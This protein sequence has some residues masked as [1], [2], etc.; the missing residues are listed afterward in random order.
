[1]RELL[2]AEIGTPPDPKSSSSTTDP[3]VELA[4]PALLM[5]SLLEPNIEAPHIDADQRIDTN[6]PRREQFWRSSEWI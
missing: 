1:M 2:G 3:R 4:V 6:C 5:D